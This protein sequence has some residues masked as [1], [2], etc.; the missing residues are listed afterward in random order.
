MLAGLQFLDLSRRAASLS[1]ESIKDLKDTNNLMR[2]ES[3]KLNAMIRNTFIFVTFAIGGLCIFGI[4]ATKIILH[5]P[6]IAIIGSVFIAAIAIKKLISYKNQIKELEK[7]T[8]DLDD[9]I[10]RV[11]S[12]AETARNISQIME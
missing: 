10:S 4:F 6:L 9:Q 2:Q 7:E 11:E 5:S 8:H 12:L 1:D 3:K